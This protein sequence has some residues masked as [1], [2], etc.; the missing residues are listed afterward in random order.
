MV[1][2]GS[3]DEIIDH[4]EIKPGLLRFENLPVDCREDTG[5]VD[6]SQLGQDGFQIIEARGA[7]IVQFS[8][9]DQERLAV[10]DQLSCGAAF[11][12]MRNGE[13]GPLSTHRRMHETQNEAIQNSEFIVLSF[14]QSSTSNSQISAIYDLQQLQ[15]VRHI[16]DEQVSRSD[17]RLPTISPECECFRC[18]AI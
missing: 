12:Q 10:D 14:I 17:F 4:L 3:L 18:S 11:V 15:E 2:P 7:G 8:S 16:A 5:G 6:S 9:E 13:T 1:A